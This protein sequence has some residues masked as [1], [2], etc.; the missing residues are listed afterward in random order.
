MTTMS[1]ADTSLEAEL[2]PAT[3]TGALGV[4]QLKRLWSRRMAARRGRFHAAT[5]HDLHLDHLVIHACGLGLEQMSRH[6]GQEAPSFEAFEQWIVITTGGVA[7]ER[8]ARINA[9]VAGEDVP[10]LTADFLAA[11]EASEPVLTQADLAFW[12]EH[13]YVVLHDAIPASACETAAEAIW[14]HLDA[15]P[16]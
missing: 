13:G 7:P 6:L 11:V 9:A 5:A 3:E 12:E 1:I 2:A 15:R 14:K 16:D 10:R 8:I 4:Y